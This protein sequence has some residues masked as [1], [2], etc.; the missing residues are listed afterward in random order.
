[1]KEK[2]LDEIVFIA[3]TEAK[4]MFQSTISKFGYEAALVDIRFT[5]W[6]NDIN[7]EHRLR[8]IEIEDEVKE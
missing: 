7:F 4:K 3:L 5:A 1:M 2:S 8:K 6:I